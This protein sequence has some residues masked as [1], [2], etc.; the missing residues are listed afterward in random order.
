MNSPM[1]KNPHRVPRSVPP[2]LPRRIGPSLAAEASQAPQQAPSDTATRKIAKGASVGAILMFLLLLLLWWLQPRGDQQA[3]GMGGGNVAGSGGAGHKGR[4]QGQE[5][6]G[7]NTSEA[8]AA[9][10]SSEKAT[11]AVGGRAT[12][13]AQQATGT[14]ADDAPKPLGLFVLEEEP[15]PERPEEESEEGNPTGDDDGAEGAEYFGEGGAGAG[16]GSGSGGTEFF[17]V[18]SKGNKF[19]YVIDCSGSMTGSK[20][21]QARDQ[22]IKSVERLRPRHRFYVYF[23]DHGDYKLLG[24]VEELLPADKEHKEYLREWSEQQ[25]GT[26]CTGNALIRSVFLKPD[27]VYFLSDGGIRDVREELRERNDHGAKINTLGFSA[28]AHGRELLEAIA[29][30]HQGQYN[31]TD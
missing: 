2:P 11:S 7:Q 27:V 10:G 28:G 29:A 19:V 21:R 31:S 12:S 23:F 9:A 8:A 25:G 22:L 24:D 17:G 26:N 18:K 6:A 13:S 30:E 5:A 15:A 1:N 20:Y 14:N 16:G 3:A 4:S